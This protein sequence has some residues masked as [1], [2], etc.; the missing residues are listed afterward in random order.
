MPGYPRGSGHP[1]KTKRLADVTIDG[2]VEG[3]FRRAIE[4]LLREGNDAHAAK[5]LKS[6]LESVCGDGLPLPAR[7]LTTTTADLTIIGRSEERRVGQEC[8]S[9]CRSRW[10]PE[11]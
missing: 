3:E 1:E 7:F 4:T 8:V 10:S 9:T 6:R 11:P 5:W 2:M